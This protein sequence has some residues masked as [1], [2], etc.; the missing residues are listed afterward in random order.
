[1]PLRSPRLLELS[2]AALAAVLLAALALGA[3]SAT[4]ATP[5]PHLTIHTLAAPTNF[6]F[7]DTKA[8]LELRGAPPGVPGALGEEPC[9]TYLVTVTNSGNAPATGPITLTDVLP[10][11]VK[12]LSV[13]LSWWQN[14][15]TTERG[16]LETNPLGR[17]LEEALCK[18]AAESVSCEFPTEIEGE[19]VQLQPDQ[20]LNME[21][22][23]TVE[24]TAESA[25]N[26]VSVSEAGVPVATSTQNDV[27]SSAPPPFGPSAFTSAISSSDG[28]PDLQAGDHPY[29]FMTAVDIT[30][31][32]GFAPNSHIL[33]TTVGHGVRDLVVDLPLGFL[34]SAQA[35]P[36]CTWAQLTEVQSCPL[37][38]L[39]GT[40]TAQPLEQSSVVSGI[41]NMVPEHGVAAEFGFRDILFNTHAIVAS[42]VPSSAGYVLRATARE[43]P[44]IRL[45]N[46][47]TTLY[48]DPASKTAA[49]VSR[50]LFTNPSDCSG[51][52]VAAT[53]H[54]DSW[55]HPGSFNADGTPNLQ[56]PGWA[57][58]S[59]QS[60]PVTGCDLLRFDPAFTLLPTS[61]LPDAPT[62][63]KVD[64]TIPQTETPGTLATPP[65]RDVSVALPRGLAVSASSATGLQ[66]CSDAQIGYLGGSASNFTPGPGSC[67]AASQIGTVR[68][69]TPL[70]EEELEG[71]VFLGSPE[72]GPCSAA[73]AQSGRMVR[74]F[75][76][77]H[78]DRMGITIKSPGSV[79]LNAA[80]GRLVSTF[81]GLPQQPFSELR[82][83]FKEGPR[84]PLSTPSACGE[85]ETAASLTPWSAPYTPTVSSPS[86]FSISGCGGSP[87][88][89]AFTAGTVSNQAGRYSPLTVSFSR[90]DPEQDFSALEAVLPPGVLAK[91]A[92]VPECGEAELNAAKA[93][94]G[95][96]PA[97]SQIGTATVA[98]GPGPQPFYTTGRV[99]LTGPYNGGPF[100]AVT[101]VPAVAGPFNL[102]NVVVRGAIRINPVT[103]QGSVVT[104]AFPS[105]LDGIPLQLRSVNVTV[106]RPGGFSFNSTTCNPSKL[107]ATIASTAGTLAA[108][109]SPYQAA[110]CQGLPFHP[111]LSASTAGITSKVNGASLHVK[112]TSSGGPDHKA[113]E[114]EAN[115]AKVELTIPNA[116]PSRLTTL[117]KA[118]T[119]AQFN[120]NP[121]AC[122][123]ESNIAT[124]IVHTPLLA[125]PL[126]GPVYF[127]S[128]GG[129]AFPDTEIILQGEGVKLLLDGHTDIKH[130]VTYSR[131][132][133]VPDAPFSSFEFFA[134]EGPYS[135]FAA[136]GNLCALRKTVT[137]SKKVTKRVKGHLRKVSVKVKSTVPAALEMPTTITAQNGAVL[138]QTAKIAV[139]GCPTA[140]A[141]KKAN[142]ARKAKRARRAA[143]RTTR[144]LGR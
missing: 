20:R 122:P 143:A 138:T 31:K 23:T 60:P 73:D 48:G 6:S 87:F 97:A 124:A 50:A 55:E 45:W 119:E 5:S 1:L 36:K 92:G 141:A 26:T 135:I 19:P 88:A 57:S 140:K 77:L 99:Y 113:G 103:A 22:A 11:G 34:G 49:G 139:T 83:N 21:V 51:Q 24:P 144:R 82:F 70:L 64:L 80:T 25:P 43:I 129:A 63:L 12:V 95:E 120:A 142:S 39:V 130:G 4:A 111:V 75:I 28:T 123:A 98:A 62:G 85:Y 137:V 33:P 107:T 94:T 38:T 58:L 101:V 86:R 61:T 71:Q 37:D 112:I 16:S 93:Q 84:A 76:Q 108:V 41:Y 91:L 54:M 121:A 32:M 81:R 27:I 128:H 116:L 17:E 47:T 102:G 59:S 44:N 114:E 29:E 14:R 133:S 78:S 10:A 118:C 89:P 3:A 53:V 52:P 125:N 132:Q 42:V 79:S 7:T 30:S 13:T 65:L 74:L 46:V 15:V 40:L 56:G 69:A 126:A 68:V 66:A 136:N 105:M 104:D 35:T 131:F 2:C 134:P 67:P 96:C 90:S 18:S 72:C 9:D 127:V 110:S 115:I 8:C 117:Q 106:D 109:S 100:G